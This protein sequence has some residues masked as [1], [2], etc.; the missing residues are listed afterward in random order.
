MTLIIRLFSRPKDSD[1]HLDFR[2]KKGFGILYEQHARKLFTICFGRIQNRVE[3]EE[4]IHNIFQSIWERRNE[5]INEDGSIE[6]YLV[7]AVKLKTIDYFRRKTSKTNLETFDVEDHCGAENLTENYY[8]YNELKDKVEFL[9]YQLPLPLTFRKVYQ[10]SREK[11]LTNKE[12]ASMFLIS[13]KTVESHM[14]KALSHLRKNLTE[15]SAIWI[16]LLFNV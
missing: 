14:T 6:R 12:I 2:T 9:V 16:A 15:Y 4:T 3:S 7:R 10:L 11:G 1:T 5:I 13:E 8:L